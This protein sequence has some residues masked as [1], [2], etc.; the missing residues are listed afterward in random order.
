MLYCC[1]SINGFAP[2][3]RKIEAVI[4]KE[5]PHRETQEAPF[6]K[7]FL[8][9]KNL[10]S[11]EA[12]PELLFLTKKFFFS[13]K[14]KSRTKKEPPFRSDFFGEKKQ[15]PIFLKQRA[16]AKKD[17]FFRKKKKEIGCASG[18]LFFL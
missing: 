10:S 18:T 6:G 13:S 11:L 16:Y 3:K 9:I 7:R 14:G 2:Q 12:I 4:P 15:N 5:Q 8:K 1:L 17:S